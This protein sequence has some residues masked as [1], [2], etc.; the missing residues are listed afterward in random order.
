M[1]YRLI[2]KESVMHLS[3]NGMLFYEIG[4]EQALDVIAIMEENGF[5]DVCCRKDYAGNDRIVYGRL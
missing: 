4:S 2:T 1:F 5:R 3:E